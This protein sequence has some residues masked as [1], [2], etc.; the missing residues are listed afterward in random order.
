MTRVGRPSRPATRPHAS[1]GWSR[2]A[3]ATIASYVAWSIV[4]MG[5]K[6]IVWTVLFRALR[7]AVTTLRAAGWRA[8]V[9]AFAYLVPIAVMLP[10]P[11]LLFII[12]LA[13][14]NIVT[15]AVVRNLAAHRPPS[16]P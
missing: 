1:S 2:R 7:A 13:L 16:V 4:S 12:G 10:R 11:D 6:V 5:P 15:F 14:L 3:C 9:L 8:L